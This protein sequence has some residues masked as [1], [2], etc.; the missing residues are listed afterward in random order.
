M[1]LNAAPQTDLC[2]LTRLRIY[3]GLAKKG[4]KKILVHAKYLLSIVNKEDDPALS[5]KF[6]SRIKMK[7]NRYLGCLDILLEW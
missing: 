5:C 6:Y 1:H 2:A 3:D 4:T 7:C